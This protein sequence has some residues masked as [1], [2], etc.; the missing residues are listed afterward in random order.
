MFMQSFLLSPQDFDCFSVYFP[1][2]IWIYNNI[3]SGL[4]AY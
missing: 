3:V 2:L 1:L 4:T